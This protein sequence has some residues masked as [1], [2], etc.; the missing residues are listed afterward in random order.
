MLAS[1]PFKSW[2]Y[3]QRAP[4][5]KLLTFGPMLAGVHIS[6]WKECIV[7]LVTD[8]R[9][10]LVTFRGAGGHSYFIPLDKN[11]FYSFDLRGKPWTAYLA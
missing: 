10:A 9:T 5:V 11:C 4:A 8:A 6:V 2:V 1:A 7:S 3:H